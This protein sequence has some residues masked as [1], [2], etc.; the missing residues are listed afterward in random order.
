MKTSPFVE[1]EAAAHGD[2]KGPCGSTSGKRDRETAVTLC[3]DLDGTLV[4]TDTLVESFLALVRKRPADLLRVP[5]WLAAG[6]ARL[7]REIARRVELDVDLLPCN[8]RLAEY[9]RQQRQSGRR[10]A[11]VTASDEKTARRIAERFGLFDE[12]L[13]SDGV[14]NLRGHAKLEAMEQRYGKGGFDYAG[15]D[16]TD[17]EIWPHSRHA[18]VV[19]P[20]RGVAKA[21]RRVAR[22][23]QLFEDRPP[24]WKT[25]GRALR[26]HQWLKNLLLFVPLIISHRIGDP[27]LMTA[28]LAGFL[29]FSLCASSVYLFNDL[30]DLEA[31]RRHPVKRRRPFAA[32]DLPLVTG[33]VLPPLLLG[34]AMA[35]ALM[36]PGT[37]LA[38]LGIYV[39][40]AFSYSLKLK[41]IP[42]VDVLVLSGLYTLRLFAG[43]VAT[44][45]PISFWLLA[46]SMF[47]FFSLAIVKRYSELAPL[48]RKGGV[49]KLAGRGYHVGDLETLR[50][51]GICSGY[52][53][54]LVLALYIHSDQ[55]NAL[56]RRPDILWA[57]CPL[58]LYWVSRAW[59]LA[60]RGEMNEDPLIFALQDRHSLLVGLMA[61]V[62]AL[63][64][65]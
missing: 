65:T 14:L 30:L 11:L 47:I 17:L 46:F 53:S 28:A 8:A 48:T 64:A 23:T 2:R 63:V 43:G 6:K 1:T 13:A 35:V 55:V 33:V 58:I 26:V 9:I 31:D 29:S 7:K 38:L 59:L 37:F 49:A 27:R 56:Y 42:L 36:L 20:D 61:L 19:N 12:V 4:K 50:V 62:V 57:L 51:F 32:G 44:G 3:I 39:L 40:T 52:L 16:H 34:T 5:A 60:G 25:L 41:R 45:I 18:L 21:A 54:V 24:R 22:V 10:V 15:N